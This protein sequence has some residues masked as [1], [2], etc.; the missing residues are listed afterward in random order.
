[1]VEAAITGAQVNPGQWS[2]TQGSDADADDRPDAG[3]TITVSFGPGET[4]PVILPPGQS[5]LEFAL[6]ESGSPISTRPDVGIGTADLVRRGGRLMITVHGLGSVAS[7]GGW[8]VLEGPDGAIHATAPF[9][10]LAAAD[11]LQPK[12]QTIGLRMPRVVPKGAWVRLVLDGDPAEVSAANNRVAIDF[13]AD[14]SRA[15]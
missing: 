2:V 4:L 14:S 9:S 12:T 13:A 8:A 10:A 5:V 6:T 15:E 7:P 3:K 11:D 1:A